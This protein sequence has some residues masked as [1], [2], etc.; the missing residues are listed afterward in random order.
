MKK[1]VVIAHCADGDVLVQPKGGNFFETKE[2]AEAA[3]ESHR[4]LGVDVDTYL[5]EVNNEICIGHIEDDDFM[6]P[7]E[8]YY[9][10]ETKAIVAESLTIKDVPEDYSFNRIMDA[11]LLYK[12]HNSS[13]GH[14]SIHYERIPEG[15]SL[16]GL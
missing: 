6:D 4:F 14:I 10:P 8:V 2:A 12:R 16:F 5:V 13:Y 15:D 7:V 1:Y 9:Y 3:A 11:W